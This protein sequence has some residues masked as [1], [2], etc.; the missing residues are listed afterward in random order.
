MAAWL[1]SLARE[2][3]RELGGPGLAAVGMCL[4]GG[5]AVAMLA[6]APVRAPVLAQPA[7][8]AARWAGRRAD[9]VLSLGLRYEDDPAVGTRFETL[10]RE[11]GDTLSRWS[12]RGPSTQRSPSTASRLASTGSSPSSTRS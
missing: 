6:D 7:S 2:L 1:Q 11:L 3:H 8:Q 9:L 5:Y 12:S 10:R 4:T